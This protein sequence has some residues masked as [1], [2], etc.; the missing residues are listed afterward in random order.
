MTVSIT[1]KF[2][3]YHYAECCYLFIVTLNVV[4]LSFIMLNVVTLSVVASPTR[5]GSS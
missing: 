4:M 5:I 2:I 1:T 3:K